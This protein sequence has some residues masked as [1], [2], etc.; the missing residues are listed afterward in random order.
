MGDGR[1]VVVSGGRRRLGDA[2]M[3]WEQENG[4]PQEQEWDVK[5]ARTSESESMNPKRKTSAPD[6]TVKEKQ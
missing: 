3:G 2:D 6:I 5:M 1:H 4:R